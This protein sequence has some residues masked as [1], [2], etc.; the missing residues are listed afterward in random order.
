VAQL[1]VPTNPR[2]GE[3]IFRDVGQLVLGDVI[4]AAYLPLRRAGRVIFVQPFARDAERWVFV[5]YEQHDG[6]V[7]GCSFLAGEGVRLDAVGEWVDPTGL[8]YGRGDESPP[9][10]TERRVQAHWDA[11]VG[12]PDAPLVMVPVLD[13]PMRDE[14]P[15]PCP[16]HG[17][18]PHRHGDGDLL[19]CR[20]CDECMGSD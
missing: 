20:I 12:R 6:N 15:R 1:K 17:A 5:A 13:V 19:V 9:P 14:Q 7:E 8:T 4:A 16:A 18:H 11:A 2:P 3:P 10:S